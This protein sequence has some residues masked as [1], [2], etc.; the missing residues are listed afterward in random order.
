[1]ADTYKVV[2]Y[3]DVWGNAK[4]G[5]E[6]NNLAEVGE[7]TVED[8]TSVKEIIQALKAIDFL[9]PHVRTNMFEVYNDYEMIEFSR[10]N[11]KP[12]FRLELQRG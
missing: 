8:Y 4:D 10:K 11:G 9:A 1:M 3:F 7:I 2:H 12:F 6:V 5:F